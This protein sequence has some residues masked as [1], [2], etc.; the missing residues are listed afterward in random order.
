VEEAAPLVAAVPPAR[1]MA[2]GG[3]GFVSSWP[4]RPRINADSSMTA[5]R[6]APHPPVCTVTNRKA[7]GRNARPCTPPSGRDKEKT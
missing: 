6:I 1:S 4:R 7:S 5:R 3:V 2:A